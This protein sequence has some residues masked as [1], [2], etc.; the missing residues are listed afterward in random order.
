[1]SLALL[2]KTRKFQPKYAYI[3]DLPSGT[4]IR[5]NCE[6]CGVYHNA[7]IYANVDDGQWIILTDEN[8]K[9][10]LPMSVFDNNYSDI[11]VEVTSR[12]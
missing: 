7:R 6:I 4:H 11:L 2:R 3:R 9:D 10:V 8:V 12:V 5:Y 1:M